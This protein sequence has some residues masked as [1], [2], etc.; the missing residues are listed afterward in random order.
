MMNAYSAETCRA[1]LIP[2]SSM[3]I[4]TTFKDREIAAPNVG[5]SK[6][7]SNKK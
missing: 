2:R 4:N 3:P 5:T 1:I 6:K 7:K